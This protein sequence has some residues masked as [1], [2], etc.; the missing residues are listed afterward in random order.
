MAGAN[1]VIQ[2]DWMSLQIPRKNIVK[3]PHVVSFFG[4]D[5][6][7]RYTVSY[8]DLLKVVGI[9]NTYNPD[10]PKWWFDGDLAR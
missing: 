5:I 6:L 1:L 7:Y 10:S 4:C 9:N 8:L 2:K 3:H